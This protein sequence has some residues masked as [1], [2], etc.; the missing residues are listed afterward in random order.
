MGACDRGCG[1]QRRGGADRGA[2][3]Y[4]DRRDAHQ[5]QASAGQ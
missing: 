5:I 4:G 2:D 3:S 1:Q